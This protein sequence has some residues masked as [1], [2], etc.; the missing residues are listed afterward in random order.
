[1]HSPTS[2]ARTTP[3]VWMTRALALAVLL[4]A[5]GCSDLI[6]DPRADVQWD[7]GGSDAGEDA[8]LDVGVDPVDADDPGDSAIKPPDAGDA[9]DAPLP[10]IPDPPPPTWDELLALVQVECAPCHT[11]RVSGELSLRDDAGLYDRL[12]ADAFQA[13]ALARV[14]PGDPDASYLWLK[15]EGRQDEVGGLGERMPADGALD[16]EQLELVRAWIAAGAPGP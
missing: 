16:A 10:D 3:A 8:A 2:T 12:R 9:T 14:A 5:A 11:D 6:D 4:G 7:V 1:M 15:L 13:P